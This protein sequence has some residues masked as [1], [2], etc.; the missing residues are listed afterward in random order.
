LVG[1]ANISGEVSPILIWAAF[2]RLLKSAM[3]LF[4]SCSYGFADAAESSF[5]ITG[6]GSSPRHPE[7]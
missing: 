5:S 3:C 1:N 6:S 2:V 7:L 4:F